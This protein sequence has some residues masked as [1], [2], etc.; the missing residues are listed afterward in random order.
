M[1]V[2]AIYHNKGG[3]GK[4]TTTVNLAAALSKRDKQVLVIDLDSQANTTF[5]TGLMKFRDEVD[6]KL[7]ICYIYHVIQEKNKYAI[8]E[9]VRGSKFTDPEFDVIPSHIDLMVH[10]FALRETRSAEFRLATKLQKVQDEYDVV[11]IDTPP[12]MNLYARIALITAD[13][14]VIPSDLKPFANEGLVNVKNF[15]SEINEYREET[16]RGSVEILGVLPSKVPTNNRFVQYTLPKMEKIVQEQYGY[17]L[18]QS[19]IFERR[20]VSAAIEQIKEVGEFDIPSPQSILDYKPDCQ[21]S[22]EFRALATEI[23][24]LT[25]L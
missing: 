6:N 7:K 22:D 3:V 8:S 18:L 5:A 14:L 11:L 23:I 13:Y 19:H 20:D 16:G 25:G 2:I 12:A 1:K 4:T 15:V 9:V 21:S 10:E 24:Q 17:N